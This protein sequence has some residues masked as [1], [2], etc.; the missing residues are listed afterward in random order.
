MNRA[1]DR[2]A[3]D[4][5]RLIAVALWDGIAADQTSDGP[6]D[7]LKDLPEGMTLLGFSLIRDELRPESRPAIVVVGRTFGSARQIGEPQVDRR[8]NGDRCKP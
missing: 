4:G 5:Y 3:D 1:I 6:S 2:K 8:V 7:D